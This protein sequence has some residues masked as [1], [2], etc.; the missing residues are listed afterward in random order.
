MGAKISFENGVGVL[1]GAVTDY[2]TAKERKGRKEKTNSDHGRS[3]F[4]P[5]VSGVKP[6]LQ[7]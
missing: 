7:V 4:I 3:G 1:A 6:D 2:L 5:D